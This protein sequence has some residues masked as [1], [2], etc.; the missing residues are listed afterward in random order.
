MIN[1]NGLPLVVMGLLVW[2]PA[3]LYLY[4]FRR[5][6]LIDVSVMDFCLAGAGNGFG[7]VVLVTLTFGGLFGP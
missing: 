2:L 7:S 1:S 4:R 5:S 6:P 3:I